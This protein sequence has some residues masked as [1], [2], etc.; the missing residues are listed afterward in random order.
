M[1]DANPTPPEPGSEPSG[2]EKR[3][4]ERI[5]ILG[6]LQGEVMV[7]QPMSVK[8]VSRGGA[9]VETA[10]PLVLDSLHDFRLALGDRAVILKG[11]V[12]H[13]SISDV[14]HEAVFYRSG[15]EFIQ[16]S[17][18]VFNVITDFI[19]SIKSGRRAL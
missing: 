18:R 2:R 15:V 8:E 10:F 12:V 1:A 3:I 16:P 13:C 7:F 4:T 11:R 19:D 5:P 17:D 14:E 6:D 9:L